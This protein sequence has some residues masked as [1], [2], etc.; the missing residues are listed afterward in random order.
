MRCGASQ[1]PLRLDPG[2]PDR[3]VKRRSGFGLGPFALGMRH[4]VGKL[5]AIVPFISVYASNAPTYKMKQVGAASAAGARM[6]RS[7]RTQCASA[8]ENCWP[9]LESRSAAST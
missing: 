9:E 7:W 4:S 3:L 5:P 1:R 2:L 8:G 6:E